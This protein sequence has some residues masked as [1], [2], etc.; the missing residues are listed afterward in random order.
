MPNSALSPD[1]PI[2]GMKPPADKTRVV[3]TRKR[4]PTNWVTGM[5]LQQSI[6]AVVASFSVPSDFLVEGQVSELGTVH[7][8]TLNFFN[9]CFPPLFKRKTLSVMDGLLKRERLCLIY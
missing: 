6:E 3:S 7:H 2:G 9:T 5:R 4:L 8:L 1:A